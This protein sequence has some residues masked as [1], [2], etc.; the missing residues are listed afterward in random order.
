MP[1]ETVTSL[2][3][4]RKRYHDAQLAK[5]QL[6]NQATTV[7]F[8]HYRSIL[9]NQAVVE[10]AEKLLKEFKPV[11]YDVAAHVKAIEAFETKAVC[12]PESTIHT[13][14]SQARAHPGRERQRH[15]CQ[16]R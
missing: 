10:Q 13:M 3:A 8:G 6:A 12:L 7:D 11:S 5:G 9:K 2:N 15:R 4:F 16:D 1:I 14:N